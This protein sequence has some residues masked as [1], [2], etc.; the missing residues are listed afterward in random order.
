M[1]RARNVTTPDA[2]FARAF[3]LHR[4]GR[5]NE[6]QA[7]FEAIVATAPRHH[8][9][10]Y[11]LGFIA[12]HSGRNEAAASWLARAVATDG[13]NVAYRS[14][15]GEALRRLGRLGEAAEELQRAV[16]L[17]PDFAEGHF[18]LGLVLM[19]AGDRR[20][21]A[22][23][24]ARAVD[25]KPDVAVFHERLGEALCDEGDTAAAAAHFTCAR[26]RAEPAAPPALSDADSLAVARSAR[27]SGALV[28]A[29]GHYHCAI[30]EGRDV[31]H[32]WTELST[33]LETLGRTDGAE[34]AAQRAVTLDPRS[35]PAHAALAAARVLQHRFDDAVTSCCEAIR[36]DPSS[37][38]AHFH[39][40]NARAA[41]GAVVEAVE[42]FRRAV[43]LRP[44]QQAAHSALLF[45]MPYAPG[46]DLGAIGREARAWAR[47]R[48]N[49]LTSEAR[50]HAN[51][52]DPT[53]RI[54]VGYVSP[55]LR[56]HPVSVFLHPL[57]EHHDRRAV[58]VFCYASVPTPDA[59]T[60]RLRARADG[61]RD[62]AHVPD[63]AVA[64]LVCEDRIDVLV[65]LSMHASGG[66][67]LLF[68]RKP[69]P[70]QVCWLAYI[71]TTGMRAMDY[72]I[73]DP[74][75]E[76]PGVHADWSTETPLALPDSFWCY[77]P[78][79]A[80]TGSAPRPVGP[81]PAARSGR[82][83]FGSQ[84]SVQKING[85]VVALWARVLTSVPSS[86]L[87]LF[88]PPAAERSL[89]G[90]FEREGVARERVSCRPLRS[91][92]SYLDA[93]GEI[94]VCLD[95]FPCSGATSSMDA[96]WMG[97]PVVTMAGDTPAGRAGL[98]I[99]TNVGLTEIVARTPDE[100]VSIA[101]ALAQD[102]PRLARMRRELRARMEGSPL[103]DAPR[104]ARALEG[105][106]RTA[107]TRW[108]SR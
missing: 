105:A 52:P 72:R 77:A 67:P 27:A 64:E 68:A 50:P 2:S 95:T 3:E 58:E 104:F 6:A 12:L 10:L 99:A 9:S 82:V 57:L 103:M 73:T 19:Q 74:H 80:L 56:T 28:A 49:R 48:A 4:A 8:P 29:V 100:Y 38:I 87:L 96:L 16:T 81:L 15:L 41:K 88:A 76:P 89:L 34:V 17:K 101:V 35:A 23:R 20:G 106:Y 40:G 54:R 21:G 102:V 45:F 79:S 42:A 7:L 60:A 61:W 98:S 51:D 65:D 92:R 36:L 53:R 43:E 62:V 66:R 84:H 37:W 63:A 70:V 25:L 78:W 86:T 71:G 30:A 24:V 91:L 14:G 94:D 75:L 44:D 32:A 13:A 18:N 59:V 55:D 33:L 107:W 93:Y 22:A 97:V 85:D 31:A 69:A 39:L 108:C 26:L 5:V 1:A 46:M 47:G 90:A 11:A 83:T